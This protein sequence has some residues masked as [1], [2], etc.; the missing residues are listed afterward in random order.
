MKEVSQPLICAL[1][2]ALNEAENLKKLLPLLCK[3]LCDISPKYEVLVVDDGST[4]NTFESILELSKVYPLR[5]IQLTRNFG[6]EN[7]I[8]AGLEHVKADVVILLDADFQHPLHFIPEFFNLWQQG[9]DMIYAVNSQHNYSWFRK[10]CGKWFYSLMDSS[11]S[12]KIEPHAGDFRLIDKRVVDSI[13]SLP[14]RNRFMKG[15]YSWVGYKT[16]GIPVDMEERQSGT[17]KYN[18]RKLVSLA[19]I[20]IT[21]F[22]ALPLRIW[23]ILGA[24]VSLSSITFGVYVVLKT[25]IYG[26][27]TPGWATLVASITLL[28]GIQLLSIGVLGEYIARIFTEVKARPTYLIKKVSNYDKADN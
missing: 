13:C 5:C 6:K 3:Q 17:S 22:S 25:L 7:A 24:L 19:V 14:E 27:E 15:I 26:I 16:I 23:G 2:P 10:I 11:A 18:F 21:S 8:T 28:S 12:I 20:G 9:Y 1:I 4:D